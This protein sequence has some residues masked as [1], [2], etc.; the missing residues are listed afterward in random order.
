MDP[1]A[2]REFASR[3]RKVLEELK[4]AHWRGVKARLGPAEALHV[5]DGLRQWYIARHPGWPDERSREE[6][7]AVH[8]RVSEALRSISHL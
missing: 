4:D 2:I 1:G 8:I 7:L 3:D 5:A 6:D